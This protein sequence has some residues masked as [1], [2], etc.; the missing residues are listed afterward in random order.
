MNKEREQEASFKFENNPHPGL[1]V[2]LEGIDAC[3]KNTQGER[4]AGLLKSQ[5]KNVILTEEP[6]KDFFRGEEIRAVLEHRYTEK[7][8]PSP[9]KF[10][11]WYVDNRRHHLKELIIPSL[12]AK[13][14]VLTLRSFWS[15]IAY[16]S[17]GVQKNTLIRLNKDFIAPDLTIFLDISPE[18]ALRRKNLSGKELEFF[19]KLEKLKKVSQSYQWLTKNFSEQITTV[20]GEQSE[21]KITD[22]IMNLIMKNP[23]FN[24]E[25][26][27][28]N[29]K[30]S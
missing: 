2:C 16:G 13:Q 23:K 9:L 10:Q 21:K 6:N 24:Q 7:P 27:N 25:K 14:I 1:F 11:E 29:I 22:Q 5:G 8:I 26:I 12:E 15:T 3:G 28:E 18:E 19:E 30:S 20:N 17:L 4:I